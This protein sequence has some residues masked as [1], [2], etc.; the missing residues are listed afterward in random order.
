L[1]SGDS[2]CFYLEVAERTHA[3]LFQVDSTGQAYRL[4]PNAKYR[5]AE[6]PLQAGKGV[7]VPNEKEYLFLDENRAPEEDHP[8]CLGDPD[9]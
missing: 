9:R 8:G 4:F 3:Y 5:T 1:R 6:N 7:W 2:Y